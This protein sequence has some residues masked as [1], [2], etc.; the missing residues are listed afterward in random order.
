MFN[1]PVPYAALHLANALC[2]DVAY[3][4]LIAARA[5]PDRALALA[6]GLTTTS[7]VAESNATKRGLSAFVPS[8]GGVRC[9][10]SSSGPAIKKPEEFNEQGK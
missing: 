4:V 10:C 8:N 2:R 9:F 7:R 6:G 5:D 3:F 1:A